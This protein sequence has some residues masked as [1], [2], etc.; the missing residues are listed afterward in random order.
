MN[1]SLKTLGVGALLSSSLLILSSCEDFLDRP[2]EDSYN[3]E[4]YYSSDAAC[5]SGVNYLS[6]KSFCALIIDTAWL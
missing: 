4:N 2:T 5:I 6:K 1:I 3:T